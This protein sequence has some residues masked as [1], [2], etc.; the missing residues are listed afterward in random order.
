[1]TSGVQPRSRFRPRAGRAGAQPGKGRG[2]GRALAEGGGVSAC[3]PCLWASPRLSP[4]GSSRG[5]SPRPAPRCCGQLRPRWLTV[6]SN[7]CQPQRSASGPTPADNGELRA[8]KPLKP[9]R[10]LPSAHRNSVA[11]APRPSGVRVVLCAGESSWRSNTA[12]VPT[13]RARGQLFIFQMAFL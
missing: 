9:S 5:P 10:G 6:R 4:A 12:A 1:M 3:L 8:W 7:R 2:Q 11:N 13:P